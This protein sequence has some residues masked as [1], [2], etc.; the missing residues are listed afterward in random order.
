[1]TSGYFR[2]F[3]FRRS[4]FTFRMIITLFVMFTFLPPSFNQDAGNKLF[5]GSDIPLFYS[6]G[7]EFPVAKKLS[8]STRAGYLTKPYDKIILDILKALGT[9]EALTNTIGEAFSYGIN[10]Q[11]T[12]QWY[13]QQWHFGIWFSF[14]NLTATEAPADAI[15]NYYGIIL[16]GRLLTPGISFRLSSNLYNGGLVVG[17]DFSIPSLPL[18]VRVELSAGKSF[19][20][21]S[22]L[23]NETLGKLDTASTLIQKELGEEYRKYGYLPS[24][25]I[26][27]VKTF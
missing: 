26:Y 16:P 2:F 21:T 23:S 18:Q 19:S 17:R 6:A 12:A 7:I 25:N 20:S 27:L 10:A 22:T 1:M 4:G 3:R 11:A 14:V 8:F 13:M 9:K 24:L 15:E 5:A